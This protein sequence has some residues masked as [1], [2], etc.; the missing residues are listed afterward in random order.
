MRA[1]STTRA[2]GS[3]ATGAAAQSTVHWRARRNSFCAA[4]GEYFFLTVDTLGTTAASTPH[5]A[6]CPTA[7]SR[8]WRDS[9]KQ[10]FSGRRSGA[11]DSGAKVGIGPFGH[12]FWSC[13]SASR[14][15]S[16]LMPSSAFI[17]ATIFFLCRSGCFAKST[18]T[19][20]ARPRT[21]MS[22]SGAAA[23]SS[24]TGGRSS[25]RSGAA[26][27]EARM[28]CGY[29]PSLSKAERGCST[30]REKVCDSRAQPPKG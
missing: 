17:S 1:V 25:G 12:A 30:S 21:C 3:A 15:F 11:L 29:M 2:A 13:L 24:S 23:A 14:L 22:F 18:A 8:R 10:T 28:A 4:G 19:S 16:W 27:S 26:S 6:S 5:S 9:G 7:L 20:S